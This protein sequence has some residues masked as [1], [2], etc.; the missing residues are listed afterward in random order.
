MSVF[1]LGF[2]GVFGNLV[3]WRKENLTSKTAEMLSAHAHIKKNVFPG[4]RKQINQ[5]HETVDRSLN[6]DILMKIHYS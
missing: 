3:Y 2:L 6:N 4:F 1:G 5:E